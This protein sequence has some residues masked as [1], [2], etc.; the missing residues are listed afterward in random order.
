ML[1]QLIQTPAFNLE[2][3]D[4]SHVEKLRSELKRLK[5]KRSLTKKEEEQ[6]AEIRETLAELPNWNQ[7]SEHEKRQLQLMEEISK[8]LSKGE[9]SS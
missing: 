5:A 8:Q 4:S 1:H 6:L 7:E 3:L 9:K 2:T